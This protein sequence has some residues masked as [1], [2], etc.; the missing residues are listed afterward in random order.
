[1]TSLDVTL[2]EEAMTGNDISHV[3]LTGTGSECMRMRNSLLRFF[4]LTIVVVQHMSLRMTERATGSHVTPKVIPLGLC[5][6]KRKLKLRYIRPS[7]A[8]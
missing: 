4:L 2:L 1:M 5:M 6:R 7:G 8:F 3:T